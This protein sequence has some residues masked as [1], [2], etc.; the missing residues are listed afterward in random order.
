MAYGKRY[1]PRRTQR[2]APMRRSGGTWGGYLSTAAKALAV[3]YSVKKM[4]NVETKFFDT[5][6]AQS[7]LTT[8]VN[9]ALFYPQQGVGSSQREGLS[10]KMTNIDM[11]LQ[12]QAGAAQTLPNNCRVMLVLDKQANG[13]QAAITDLLTSADTVSHHQLTNKERFHTLLDRVYKVL[14]G[15]DNAVHNI[16]F[17]KQFSRHFLFKSTVGNVTD[18]STANIFLVIIPESTAALA[19]VDTQLDC[20]VRYVDN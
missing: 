7:A 11:N 1:A 13:A 2:R 12:I 20:R 9:M 4:L 14:P 5:T 16:H 15:T 19:Q 10:V 17:H 8:N 18:L 3:A 6:Y